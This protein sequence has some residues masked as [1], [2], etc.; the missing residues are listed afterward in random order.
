[1][2]SP[3]KSMFDKSNLQ[4]EDLLLLEPFQ[5]G[6][7]PGYIPEIEFASVLHAYPVIAKP[8]A[9]NASTGNRFNRMTNDKTIACD[10]CGKR[11]GGNTIGGKYEC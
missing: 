10:K 11:E 5:V 9:G 3:L 7:L 4:V 6:C 1:M 2:G 8:T